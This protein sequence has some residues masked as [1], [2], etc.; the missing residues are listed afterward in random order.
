VRELIWIVFE[1]SG[2]EGKG[3]T[4]IKP[5]ATSRTLSWRAKSEK[6]ALEML[7]ICRYSLISTLN[8]VRESTRLGYDFPMDISCSSVEYLINE[9]KDPQMTK[10]SR[11]KYGLPHKHHYGN[12]IE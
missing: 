8:D 2:E 1:G 5:T 12:I 3:K 4:Y 6:P 7:D 11:L 10:K 9:R